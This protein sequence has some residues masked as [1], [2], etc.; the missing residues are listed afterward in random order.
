MSRIFSLLVVLIL[1]T[2][3]SISASD[4]IPKDELA[5]RYQTLAAAM[6][7]NAVT[8]LFSGEE[9]NRSN[10][11]QWPFRQS[12]EIN[13]FTG[14]TKR[15]TSFALVKDGSKVTTVIFAQEADP[16]FET[17][18]GRISDFDT[19]KE[20]TGVD[21]VISAAEMPDFLSALMNGRAWDA[22]RYAPARFPSFYR[23]VR[24]T[25]ATIWLSLG[26]YR[27]TD[28]TSTPALVYAE[29][30]KQNFP[31]IAVRNIT[32]VINDMRE[33]KSPWELKQLQ[34]A[35]DITVEA[36]KEAM[37]RVV[38]ANHEYQVEATIEFTFR[39]K[40]A[41]CPSYPSIVASGN[42]ATVLHY[43]E[44]NDIIKR[45]Q[46]LLTDVGAELNYYA[47]D[48]TRTY[49]AS[50]KFSE[51]QA[52]IYNAVLDGQTQAIAS[53]KQG[54]IAQELEAIANQTMGKHLL[55]LGLIEKNERDQVELYYL[56]G[57]S[58]T[59]GLDVH[60]TW[61][62][63]LEL[64]PNMVITVEPGLYVRKDDVF[65]SDV[66]KEMSETAQA[67]VREN[68]EKYE[69]IG[70]RIEDDIL[71]QENSY[72]NMSVGAPRTIADIEAFMAQ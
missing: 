48:T 65:N 28:S 42:N 22:D 43:D 61:E 62:T 3:W 53:V 38:T 35:I 37:K 70:V 34:D 68:I 32:P 29:K 27:D 71:V 49:P 54:I 13:Y 69:G 45:D 17:W 24:N 20:A 64:R 8:L 63:D 26:R 46:L 15:Q 58:H 39:D 50:G 36:Q 4:N 12:N 23:A 40:G 14:S 51:A 11:I 9:K 60:D 33:I 7:D 57:L 10:D 41:C 18:I 47:A 30:V 44:N 1:T 16:T 56:H 19:I 25:E 72:V 31:D 66:F 59:I 5:L 21:L 52:A 55:A 6:P 2:A 67:M